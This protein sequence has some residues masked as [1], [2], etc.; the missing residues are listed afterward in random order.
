VAAPHRGE[1]TCDCLAAD[2]EVGLKDVESGGYRTH[3]KRLIPLK[4][5]I[6]VT[7]CRDF[8]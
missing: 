8:F 4:T 5:G 3:R 2:E 1:T 6:T 7:V